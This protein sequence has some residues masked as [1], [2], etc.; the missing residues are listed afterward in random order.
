M[1]TMSH[2]EGELKLGG[3]AVQKAE[4]FIRMQHMI[5]ENFQSSKLCLNETKPFKLYHTLLRVAQISFQ[6]K[7]TPLELVELQSETKKIIPLIKEI[8]NNFTIFPKIHHMTHYHQMFQFFRPL[9]NFSA[10]KY[11]RKHQFF[12]RFFNLSERAISSFLH[13]FRYHQ[14]VSIF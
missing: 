9:V 8:S 5:V 1:L 4:F 14:P 3:D 2:S 10:L 13:L 7:I 11:E 12:K 6:S